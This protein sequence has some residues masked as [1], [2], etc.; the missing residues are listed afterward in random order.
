LAETP[1]D[2]KADALRRQHALNPRPND[3][4]DPT[5]T[6]GNVSFDARDVVQVKY[7]MLRR[8][9]EE[10]QPVSRAGQRKR[11]S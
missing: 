1:R 3:V 8:V 7:E 4:H 9:R 6:S 11:D 5:F 10:G 2:E